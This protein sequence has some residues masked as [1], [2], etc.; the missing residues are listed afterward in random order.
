MSIDPSKI[1]CLK[2]WG[3]KSN[4]FEEIYRDNF[5]AR[6]TDDLDFIK[7]ILSNSISEKEVLNIL[8]KGEYGSGKTYSLN[9][10]KGFVE[11]N[12]NGFG[13][14]FQIPKKYQV[15]GFR[16]IL[17][18][19]IRSIEITRL[20]KIANE[21]VE[22]EGFTD[23]DDF[24][25]HLINLRIDTDVAVAISNLA[26]SEDYALTSTW[27][28]GNSTIHQDRALGMQ[29]S[30][31]DEPIIVKVIINI[32]FFLSLKYQI[33]G[34]F[35][36]EFE[37]LSGD[38][39]AVKSVKEGFRNL[40]DAL[41]ADDRRGAIAIVTAITARVEYE[42]S[43]SMGTAFLDRITNSFTLSPLNEENCKSYIKQLFREYRETGEDKL[44]P[45][46]KNDIAFDAYI[47]IFPIT[48]A[49]PKTSPGPINT[50]RR[51]MKTGT[52]LL[53]RACFEKKKEIDSEFIEK[54]LG[55]VNL[56]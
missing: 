40:Y 11:K 49:V 2:K 43:S 47:K 34:I 27:L 3:F 15:R 26:F 55:K 36:D 48:P 50:P 22:K 44:V 4:P 32:L 17:S 24:K 7:Y 54:I 53:T 25:K 8:I 29:S 14:F 52:I 28:F 46:F 38:S 12:L 16:D 21:I 9:Y 35:V 6:P 33:V 5:W 13:I 10:L 31:K 45:P 19:F 41:L 1:E 51:I 18:E 56:K 37:N 39:Q 30:T 42:I 23:K 20:E